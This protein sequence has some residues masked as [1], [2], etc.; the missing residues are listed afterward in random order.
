MYDIIKGRLKGNYPKHVRIR[1]IFNKYKNSIQIKAFG[2][3][4]RDRT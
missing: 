1:F 2:G 3:F 4:V